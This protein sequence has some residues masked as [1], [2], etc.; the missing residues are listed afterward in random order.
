MRLSPRDLMRDE[1]ELFYAFAH[2]QKGDYAKAADFAAT[3]AS[4]RPG[5]AYP[6][7]ILAASSALAGDRQ[8]AAAAVTD[9]LALT[10]G[11][12]LVQAVNQNVYQRDDDRAR[13][14][15]GLRKA[16]LPE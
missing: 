5:H 2:F 6:Y 10:P 7:R 16:G 12:D 14:I 3:A 4:L 13:L 8:R 11:F 15:D 1:F 9:M